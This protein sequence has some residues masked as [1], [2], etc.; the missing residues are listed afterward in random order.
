MKLFSFGHPEF[1]GQN[2]GWTMVKQHQGILRVTAT[3][4]ATIFKE[5]HTQRGAQGTHGKIFDTGR[6]R[7]QTTKQ[8]AQPVS[9]K[10]M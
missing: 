3:C 8:S 4:G 1:S 9:N 5:A 6:V 2:M 7:D 10:I